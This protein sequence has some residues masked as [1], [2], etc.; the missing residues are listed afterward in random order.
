VYVIAQ[1]SL[2]LFTVPQQ[3]EEIPQEQSPQEGL[4]GIAN[5]EAAD[6]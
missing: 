2:F 1:L 3:E 6:L 5:I 4:S